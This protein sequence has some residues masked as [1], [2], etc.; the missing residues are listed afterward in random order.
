MGVSLFFDGSTGLDLRDNFVHDNVVDA[1]DAV[2]F[3][4]HLAASITCSNV[5]DGCAAAADSNNNRFVRNTYDIPDLVGGYFY[6]KGKHRTWS[7]WQAAGRDTTGSA[8]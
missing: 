2:R 4:N 3:S 7:E 1:S 5:T 8:Y 6:F